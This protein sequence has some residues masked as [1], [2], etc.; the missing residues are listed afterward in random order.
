MR[1]VGCFK[2]V[3]FAYALLAVTANIEIEA[4]VKIT[5]TLAAVSFLEKVFE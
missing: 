2:S 1:T 5:A 4:P 3:S